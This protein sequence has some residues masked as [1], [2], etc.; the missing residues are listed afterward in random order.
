MKL[1][2][3]F[4]RNKLE[5]KLLR[6]FIAVFI[7]LLFAP[8]IQRRL[9]I[10]VET[11]LYGVEIASIRPEFSWQSWKI[12]NFQKNFEQWFEDRIGFR[13]GLIK[14]NNQIDFDVFE[15]LAQNN[16]S[17]IIL[18]KNNYL[19]EKGNIDSHNNVFKMETSL[20]E[21]EIQKLK[22]LQD[23]LAAKDVP[24]LLIIS[25]NKATIYPEYIPEKYINK[26]ELQKTSNYDEIIFFLDKYNINYFD[27][28]A[29]FLAQREMN[30]Y[31]LF[32]PGGTH[33]SYYGA[34][35]VVKEL[36]QKLEVLDQKNLINISCTPVIRNNEPYGYDIDLKNL[37][38][39]WT[40]QEINNT[41]DHPTISRDEDPYA[42]QPNLLFIGDS[43]SWQILSIMDGQKLYQE[44]DFFYYYSR[45]D[46]YPEKTFNFIDKENFDWKTEVLSKDAI[47]MEINETITPPIWFG[48]VDDALN[49]LNN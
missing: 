44:R 19:Y 37:V 23:K 8:I 45:N 10:F 35:L 24:F 48:F 28:H 21:T 46:T 32:P 42:Y 9:N 13:A 47:I 26:N 39:L 14:T 41:T 30:D 34:C 22:E 25:P 36:M 33:W 43:F 12:E 1:F 16:N 20:I 2:N 31:L 4:H 29:F 11:N 49:Y 38:N 40:D 6:I 27:T 5:Q 18:G 7:I 15:E 17:K 3:I